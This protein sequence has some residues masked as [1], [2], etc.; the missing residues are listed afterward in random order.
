MRTIDPH[1]SGFLDETGVNMAM[2][3]HYARAP[4]GARAYASKPVNKGKHSTVVGALS[5]EGIIAAMTVEGRTDSEV[6]LTSVQPMLVPTWRPGQVVMMDNLSSHPEARLQTAS[7]SV[8]APLASLPPDSP[9]LS[10]LAECWSK[11]TEV[12]RAQAARTRDTRDAA[13]TAAFTRITP[14]E[15]SGWFAHCG[16]V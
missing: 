3:R 9:D 4:H 12:L 1:E 15:A 2:A 8:G 5:R 16:Y 6:L 13:I 11:F 14:Q 7:E 10:P